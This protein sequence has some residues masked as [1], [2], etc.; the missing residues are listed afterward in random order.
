MNPF[1]RKFTLFL[2]F[3]LLVTL[4][5]ANAENAEI[6]TPPP[7]PIAATAYIL[8]DFHTGKVLAENNADAKLAPA[9]LTKI[10]TV[11][12]VFRELSNGH[13]HLEDMATISEKAWKTSGSRMFVELGNQVK[14]E[15]L[16]KGVIIQSGN[17]ASVA[18][19]EHVAGNEATFADMMNQ[20]AARLG[21]TNSHFKNSDGLPM[22]DHYTSARDLAILTTALIK[23][24]PDYYRWFSQK[25]FTFNKIT[26]QNRNQ[27]LS[28]DESVDGVKTG[29]TDEAGY[30]LVASALREDMRLISAVMGAKSAKARANENQSLLNYGF[31]FFESHRLYQGKTPLNEARIWKGSSKTIPLGLAEDLYATIPRR[32]YKD[33]KAVITVDKKITAPVIEGAKHGSVKVTLKDEVIADKDL[34]ALKTV[35]QGNIIQRLYD[36]VLMMME[37][38]D[39]GK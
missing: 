4:F 18:L 21:M 7:P 10:M 3:G 38:S 30:C 13:L 26:Q 11:Y 5:Q 31:R 15:D 32:Q 37:K 29:F 28:R 9:S 16:L 27:L 17:D 23:E 25:E 33:L 36:S 39:D 35:E 24:F 19:A 20:H 2:F 8:Q 22:E 12:V 1:K 34:I 14:V 6:A